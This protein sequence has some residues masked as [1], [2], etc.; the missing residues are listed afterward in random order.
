MV[1]VLDISWELSNCLESKAG[2]TSL[3]LGFF[4]VTGEASE[5]DGIPFGDDASV[6]G[7]ISTGP[8]DRCELKC[9]RDASRCDD[10]GRRKRV[11]GS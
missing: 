8:L 1:L 11:D 6:I 2:I 4:S 7:A 3:A 9:S 5:I 10:G